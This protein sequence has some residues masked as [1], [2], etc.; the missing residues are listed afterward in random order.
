MFIQKSIDLW[1]DKKVPSSLQGHRHEGVGHSFEEGH[2]RKKVRKGHGK[3]SRCQC[4]KTVYF[5]V[6][7]AANLKA[8]S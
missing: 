5:V 4:Y 6:T 3:I 8:K 1:Q 2:G 7:D